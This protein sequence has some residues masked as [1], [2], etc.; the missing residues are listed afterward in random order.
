MQSVTYMLVAGLVVAASACSI[1][2]SPMRAPNFGDREQ[3]ATDSG[4]AGGGSRDA[5]NDVDG[6]GGRGDASALDAGGD[7]QGWDA[8]AEPL[9]SEA[10]TDASRD[11]SIDAPSDALLPPQ[12]ASVDAA[13]DAGEQCECT[14][15]PCC[16]G[17]WFLDTA[18]RCYRDYLHHCEYRCAKERI[19]V[20]VKQYC[21]GDSAE[22]TGDIETTELSRESCGAYYC[23]EPGDGDARCVDNVPIIC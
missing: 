12:D 1:N 8:D 2:D 14:T 10:S 18:T 17:C 6:S 5:G 13:T 3:G 11:A 23:I 9:A 16:D 15:G 4:A 20:V 22:C 21:S 7:T 19:S